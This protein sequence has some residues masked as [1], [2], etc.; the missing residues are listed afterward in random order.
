MKLRTARTLKWNTIDRVASQ[1]VYALVG[2]V[3]AN[4]LS[5]EDFGLV[6]VLLIFQAFATIL[7]DSGF[8]AALLR[9]KQATEA[10]YSTVFWFNLLVSLGL[11][12]ILWL[13][14]PIIAEIFHDQRLIPLSK[15]MFVAFV[16]NG[17]AIVQTNILMK[18]MNV[19]PLAIANTIALIVSGGVGIW[20]ALAGGGAW[21]LVWQTVTLA[22]IKTS[23]LWI[24]GKWRPRTWMH[25][26][27]LSGIWKVG[28][29]VLSSSML[30]TIFLQLYN[31]AIG[32][33][34]TSLSILGIYTQAD[35]WSKMGSASISQILTASFVP[36]LASVQD[37]EKN[38]RQYVTKINRFTAF[39]LFPALGGLAAVGEPLFHTLF[40]NKWDAAIPL[41]QLLSLRGIF[42]VITSLHNNYLL[43]L[44]KVKEMVTIEVTKDV[45]MGIALLS[46]IW[47]GSLELLVIGQFAAS[48]LTFIIVSF[49]TARAT[50]YTVLQMLRDFLPSVVIS[51][52][53]I[54]VALLLGQLGAMP[55]LRLMIELTAGLATYII[56]ARLCRLS[57]LQESVSYLLGRFRR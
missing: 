56:I 22:I 7:T 54:A 35:K 3:L 4:E 44:G 9:K 10:D 47:F 36:L 11:Y 55:I 39:I 6:G 51:V 38:F 40:G 28:M 32:A 14:A 21:A 19:R 37:N 29:G 26:E 13:G 25:R 53:T 42:V 8:G 2:V 31:I 34:Y 33:W 50:H 16:V 43:A 41:F 30:N 5:E 12:V 57:E 48:F 24:W 49:I 1:L 15:V 27:S 17:L 45:M 52:L 18:Q 23:L 46:T 20:I